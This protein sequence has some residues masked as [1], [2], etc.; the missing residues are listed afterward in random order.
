MQ[1]LLQSMLNV[2]IYKMKEH[3]DLIKALVELKHHHITGILISYDGSGDSG[4]IENICYTKENFEKIE[5]IEDII[6]DIWH[7]KNALKFLSESLHSTLE[8]VGYDLLEN[9]EDWYNNDGGYGNI[10]IDVNRAI[11]H[12]DNNVRIMTSQHYEHSGKLSEKF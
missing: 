10:L 6:D 11:Y 8:D 2:K 12:I 3:E 4:S 7:N 9:V 1:C 5:E